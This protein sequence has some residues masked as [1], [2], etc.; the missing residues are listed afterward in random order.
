MR[1]A[2]VMLAVLLL[3]GCAT[4]PPAVVQP[5][6]WIDASQAVQLAAA[7]A[8]SGVV[9]TFA[10]QVQATGTDNGF[11]Y[12][13]S[14][15]DYRDQRNLSVALTPEA[16]VDLARRLDGDLSDLLPG[17]RILVSGEARRVTIYFTAG[18]QRTE[19]YYYQTHV[20]VSDA[21]QIK[22]LTPPVVQSGG[23]D[24]RTSYQ[25]A[26]TDKLV[27]SK[28]FVVVRSSDSSGSCAIYSFYASVT[29]RLTYFARRSVWQRD[30]RPQL[31]YTDSLR[32]PAL[33][34][35]VQALR[36]VQLPAVVIPGEPEA[37]NSLVRT[38]TLD[39]SYRLWSG[40][41]EADGGVE[42]EGA[43]IAPWFDTARALDTCWSR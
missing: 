36:R 41:G 32:C 11:T 35:V 3:L 25:Q 23:L 4:A 12:L 2:A 31:R 26:K 43:S 39:G 19:K 38:L 29:P 34:S 7:A 27:E 28:P 14:Q 6:T 21:S 10:L 1:M 17:K 24:C 40:L 15:N 42:F 5:V 18:G 13:N 9:G 20:T 33:T 8:P 22:V 30:A 37:V 16:A